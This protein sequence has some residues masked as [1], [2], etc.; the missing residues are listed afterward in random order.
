MSEKKSLS[1]RQRAKLVAAVEP[2]LGEGE[3]VKAIMSGQT[4]I[5][6]LA[7]MLVVPMVFIFILKFK[8]VVATDR[9]LYVLPNKFLRSYEFQSDPYK[10]PLGSASIDAGSMSVR[11]DGGPRIWAAPR[12]PANRRMKELVGY[13]REAQESLKRVGSSL[14][15]LR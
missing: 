12:G 15:H 9:N 6:P 11:I 3:E 1:D 8:T 7:N 2:Y 14:S 10:V 4:P 13:V 5:P